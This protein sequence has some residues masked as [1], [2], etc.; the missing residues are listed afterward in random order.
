M[1]TTTKLLP[2]LILA[3]S[4]SGIAS[5]DVP[6]YMVTDFGVLGPLGDYSGITAAS[7]AGAVVGTAGDGTYTRAILYD[8]SAHDLGTLGGTNSY[9]Y[10]ANTSNHVVGA[11]ETTVGD[12]TQHAFYYNGAMHDLGTLGGHNSIAVGINSSNKIIGNAD[13]T[14][15]NGSHAFLYDGSMHDLGTLGGGTSAAGAINNNGII[16]GTADLSDM[17]SHAFMYNGTMH[18]I[19]SLGGSY[20]GAAA[21]STNGIIAGS[22]TLSGD[23]AMHAF[24]YDGTMHDIGDLGGGYADVVGVNSFGWVVG[25]SFTNVG[26]AAAVFLYD[27]KKMYSLN[28]LLAGAYPTLSIDQVF[29]ISDTGQ[30]LVMGNDTN[31]MNA[32][33]DHLYSLNLVSTVPLPASTWLFGL[34]L[35]A[36]ASGLRRKSKSS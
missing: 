9:A 7:S 12:Y 21:I 19:G 26:L 11:S 1:K 28:D 34:S 2:A 3:A 24:L 32:P 6:Q 22:A 10:G 33:Y 8:G 30:I 23:S 31:N 36:L 29:G 20:A 27:G 4:V 25:N 5:A 35:A 15:N 17:T 18:D 16:V 14:D 13:I